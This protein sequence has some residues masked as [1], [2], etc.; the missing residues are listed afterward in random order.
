MKI[1]EDVVLKPP[2]VIIVLKVCDIITVEKAHT[3]IKH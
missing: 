3:I 1:L 2:L